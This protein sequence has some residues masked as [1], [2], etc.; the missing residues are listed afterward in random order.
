[1]NLDSI[2]LLENL[3]SARRVLVSGAGGGF[4]VFCG[5]PLYFHLRDRGK[6]VFLGNLSFSDLSRVHGESPAGAVRRVRADSVG[7]DDYFPEKYLCQWFERFGQEVE[8]LCFLRTGVAPLVDAY[9]AVVRELDLDAVVL[10]DGGMDSLMRGDERSIG[11]PEEDLASIA[12]VAAL[13]LKRKYL[14]CIG[15]GVDAFHGVDSYLLLENVAALIKER[16]YL[17]CFP[18][19]PAMPEARL[20]AEAIRYVRER[21]PGFPSIVSTSILSATVGEYG[22]H[23]ETERTRGSTLWIN[24][25]M[26]LY[27]C[28]EVDAVAGR[29]LYLDAIR[30]TT[31]FHDLSLAI[32]EFRD[33]LPGMRAGRDVLP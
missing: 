3:E 31:S 17:G 9:E 22:D 25:L 2:P 26:S 10:V 18:I 28:F 24:P 23:H 33:N 13:D 7:L 6:D 20:Y 4:D 14:A 15:F 12:A 1:V 11:T 8:I 16:G 19:L 5:L 32:G 21:M 27:W 30:N 29:C